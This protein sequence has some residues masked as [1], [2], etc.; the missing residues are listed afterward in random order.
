MEYHPVVHQIERL[1]REHDCVYKTFQHEAVTTSE[2]AARLRPEYSL[3]QGAKAIIVKTK[4]QDGSRRFLML[5]FP[6]D[7]KFNG[8]K[9][10]ELLGLKEHRF[11]TEPEIAEVTHGVERGGVPPFGNLFGLQVVADERLFENEIIIF[12][13]GDRRYSISMGS[14]DYRRLVNPLVASII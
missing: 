7:Q 1:L 2:E 12:N 9:V 13:A 14:A 6:A 8:A 5:V 4:E 11:A 3:H 10:K